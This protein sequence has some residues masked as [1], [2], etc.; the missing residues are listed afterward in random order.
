MN[1]IYKYPLAQEQHQ[2]VLMPQS[3]KIIAVQTQGNSHVCVWAI[4]DPALPKEERE[5]EIIGTGEEFQPNTRTHIG[6][7]QLGGFVWHVFEI[8]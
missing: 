6:T 7:V 5:F 2:K 1:V 3:A 4:V 8:L